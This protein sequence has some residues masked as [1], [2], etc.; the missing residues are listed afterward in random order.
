MAGTVRARVHAEGR[1]KSQCG[2]PIFLT[3]DASLL[4]EDGC[5]PGSLWGQLESARGRCGEAWFERAVVWV[6]LCVLVH[7]AILA[8]SASEGSGYPR[9]RFGLV[10]RRCYPQLNHAS[11]EGFRIP[12]LALRA[13]MPAVLPAIEPCLRRRRGQSANRQ[14]IRPCVGWLRP[15]WQASGLQNREHHDIVRRQLPGARATTHPSAIAAIAARERL[16]GSG[17]EFTSKAM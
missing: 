14:R 6:T 4:E 8:R 11:G 12:S 5:R 10:C 17:T 16:D 15:L 2:R 9:W 3:L 7:A 1:P 13:S